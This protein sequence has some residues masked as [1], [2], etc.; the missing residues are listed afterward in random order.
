MVNALR[1]HRG[2]PATNFSVASTGTV[3]KAGAIFTQVCH[4]LGASDGVLAVAAQGFSRNRLDKAITTEVSVVG[5]E[6][7]AAQSSSAWQGSVPSTSLIMQVPS[8]AARAG[9]AGLL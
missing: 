5:S 7:R 2:D 1:G 3:I 6:T 8:T 9:I 4:G